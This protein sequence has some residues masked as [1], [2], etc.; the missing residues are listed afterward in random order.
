MV[1]TGDST[2]DAPVALTDEMEVVIVEVIMNSAGLLET[3]TSYCS[4]DIAVE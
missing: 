1:E 4:L 2:F 3:S